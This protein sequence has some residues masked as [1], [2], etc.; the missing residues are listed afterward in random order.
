MESKPPVVLEQLETTRIVAEPSGF[1]REIY[2]RE[3]VLES[4]SWEPV[5]DGPVSVCVSEVALAELV[6]AYSEG[7]L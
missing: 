2:I 7:R 3:Q 6:R 1:G 5:Y 4:G